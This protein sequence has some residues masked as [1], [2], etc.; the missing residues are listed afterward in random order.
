VSRGARGFVGS[1]GIS[2]F[3][4]VET[5]AEKRRNLVMVADLGSRAVL[6]FGQNDQRVVLRTTVQMDCKMRKYFDLEIPPKTDMKKWLKD[7]R[8]FES[9]SCHVMVFTR[10]PGIIGFQT[11]L[12]EVTDKLIRMYMPQEIFRA[13]R[14]ENYRQLILRGQDI[15]VSL[16]SPRDL[17][18]RIRRRLM[19]IS[20]G[21]IS[22]LVSYTEAKQYKM[23]MLVRHG[24]MRIR[25]HIINF[26]GEVRA[27]GEVNNLPKI[28]GFRIGIKFRRISKDDREFIDMY[29]IENAIQYFHTPYKVG[30]LG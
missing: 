18:R 26:D 16:R 30:E 4:P 17:R 11:E 10:E 5:E 15:T 1:E 3:A 2:Q 22:I 19:D 28:E 27:V 24:F 25:G 13:Q 12:V 23:G 29:V 6:W 14:R 20:L 21:G 8:Q 9:Q 7:M